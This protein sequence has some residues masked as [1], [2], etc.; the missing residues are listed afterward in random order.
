MSEVVN[1]KDSPVSRLVL[2]DAFN[3]LMF[4]TSVLADE[5]LNLN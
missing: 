5:P 3:D 1:E 4:G 2:Q